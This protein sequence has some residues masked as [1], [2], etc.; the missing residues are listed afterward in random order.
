MNDGKGGRAE[1]KEIKKKNTKL[2]VKIFD[3]KKCIFF[4]SRSRVPR[5]ISV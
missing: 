4:L 3:R 1:I 2:I 5:F